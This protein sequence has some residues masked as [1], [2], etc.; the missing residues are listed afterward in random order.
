LAAFRTS[1]PVAVLFQ[2][3]IA[4][5]AAM[6]PVTVSW[7]PGSVEIDVDEATV[8]GPDQVS[9]VLLPPTSWRPA[10]VEPEAV[11]DEASCRC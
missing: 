10:A 3:G 7:L 8:M 6:T 1:V 2:D 11:E 5:G 9:M 4:E